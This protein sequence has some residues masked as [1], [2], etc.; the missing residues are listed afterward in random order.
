MW[1]RIEGSWKQFTGKAKE[2]WGKL[3]DDDLTE[4]AGKRDQLAGKIQE[5]YGYAKDKAEEE[6][7]SFE[8]R[9]AE[10]KSFKS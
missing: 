3:T 4:I 8:A 6:I 5:R 1:D 7:R 10:D 2:Q 9:H